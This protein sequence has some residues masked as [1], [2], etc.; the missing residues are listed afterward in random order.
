MLS[1]GEEGFLDP[2]CALYQ[3]LEN[4]GKLDSIFATLMIGVFLADPRS[5]TKVSTS[6]RD[7]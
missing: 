7:F 2:A 4:N 5:I 3:W 1:G 6:C